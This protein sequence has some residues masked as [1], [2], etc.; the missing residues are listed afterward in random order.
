MSEFSKMLNEAV[1]QSGEKVELIE[2]LT[3]IRKSTLA[4][5]RNGERFPQNEEVVQKILKAVQCS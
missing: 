4:K 5:Y 2:K 3:G 1:I